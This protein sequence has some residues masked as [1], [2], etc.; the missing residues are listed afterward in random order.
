MVRIMKS[1][2]SI[3]KNTSRIVFYFCLFVNC[4]CAVL[5]APSV[6]YSSFSVM[7]ECNSEWV[8]FSLA[9]DGSDALRCECE[10]NGVELN[11]LYVR[12][13]K[14]E[15]DEYLIPEDGMVRLENGVYSALYNPE[16]RRLWTSRVYQT[17]FPYYATDCFDDGVGGGYMHSERHFDKRVQLPDNLNDYSCVE[18]EA[19]IRVHGKFEMIYCYLFRRGIEMK[20]IKSIHRLYAITD[21]S[22][23]E[24]HR[25]TN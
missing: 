17:D 9:V 7:T 11:G 15:K 1:K 6:E 12:L 3:I 19:W 4:G 2:M 21:E 23:V 10:G 20:E 8:H 18:C 16:T 22:G 14:M 13:L 24:W 5:N 25:M